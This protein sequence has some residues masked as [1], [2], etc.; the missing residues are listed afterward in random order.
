MNYYFLIDTKLMPIKNKI[1]NDIL[2]LKIKKPC[3]IAEPIKYYTKSSSFI[4]KR[5]Y[6]KKM[7]TMGYIK[8]MEMVYYDEFFKLYPLSRE[9]MIKCLLYKPQF[10]RE[11]RNTF[12]YL[13]D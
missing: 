9:N 7:Y 6:E 5:K 2:K 8:Q 3:I 11:M 12:E 4:A 1:N 13:N 10:F